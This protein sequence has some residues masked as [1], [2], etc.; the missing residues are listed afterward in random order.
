MNICP[1]C[2][3]SM[4]CLYGLISDESI[5]FPHEADELSFIHWCQ[6]CGTLTHSA[7][8]NELAIFPT[9]LGQK[10]QQSRMVRTGPAV[11]ELGESWLKVEI[12]ANVGDFIRI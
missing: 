6:N 5:N 12:P 11:D 3:S 10:R 4:N 8:T 2:G 1:T 9:V 7:A